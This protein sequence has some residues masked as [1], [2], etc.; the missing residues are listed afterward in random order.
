MMAS[1]LIYQNSFLSRK[2]KT[3][4]EC[5]VVS[6]TPCHIVGNVASD[7]K[8]YV[9]RKLVKPKTVDQKIALKLIF[10]SL[11][12]T[13]FVLEIYSLNC[14]LFYCSSLSSGYGED[15]LTTYNSTCLKT[16][17]PDGAASKFSI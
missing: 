3:L 13:S 7:S 16:Y 5:I 1:L 10:T 17:Y 14:Q 15:A 9:V 6:S 4:L 2:Q 12:L 11:C 8:M